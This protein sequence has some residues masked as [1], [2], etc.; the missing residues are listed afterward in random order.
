MSDYH[1]LSSD[2]HGNAFSIAMHF[3][4]PNAMT[5]AGRSIR[6]ALIEHLGGSQP[7]QVPFIDGAEQTQLNAGELYEHMTELHS[8]PGEDMEEKEAQLDVMWESE[9]ATELERLANELSYWGHN[10][11]IT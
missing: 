7:S 6:E 4:I 2:K 10:R 5:L 11:V 1:I 9:K 8:N 3:P